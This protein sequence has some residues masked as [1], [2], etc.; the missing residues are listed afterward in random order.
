MR[1]FYA[2]ERHGLAPE[3]RLGPFLRSRGL[4]WPEGRIHRSTPDRDRSQ[5]RS[6]ETGRRDVKLRSAP[7]PNKN[8]ST[9][10]ICY[11]PECGA[12]LRVVISEPVNVAGTSAKASEPLIP[13][14]AVRTSEPLIPSAAVRTSEPLIPSAA[15][16]TS[17]PLIPS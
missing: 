5:M 12:R 13:S 17:E 2:V 16:R 11:C 3:G 15:V 14:A 1:L 6:V 8:E 4:A 9:D 7:E 10:D